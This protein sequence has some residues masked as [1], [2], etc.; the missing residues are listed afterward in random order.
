MRSGRDISIDVYNQIKEEGLL[1]AR[2]WEVYD[3]LF[4]FGPMTAN[5]IFERVNKHGSESYRHN[6]NPRLDEL[7]KRKVAQRV[8]EK[9]C[10]V[11]KRDI[12]LWD[13]TSNLP[14]EPPKKDKDNN[15]NK[16]DKEYPPWNFDMGTALQDF[17]TAIS[18]A[19][20]HGYQPTDR[21]RALHAWLKSLKDNP[22]TAP[23]STLPGMN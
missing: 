10:S 23:Q 18:T 7:R 5:E 17:V 1:S 13:V 6:V 3:I 12:T 20:A 4:R 2:R 21:L 8:G 14:E 22:P 16:S 11:S 9:T 19:K 15:K